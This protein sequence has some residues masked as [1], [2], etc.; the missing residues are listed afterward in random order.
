MPVPN[1]RRITDTIKEP[2]D[3]KDKS[4]YYT[5]TNLL[6]LQN[7]MSALNGSQFKLWMY[8]SKNQNGHKFELSSADISKW[9]L[10][11]S[12]YKRAFWDLVDY[13][14]LEEVEYNK[15]YKF[16]EKPIQKEEPIIEIVKDED[17][18]FDF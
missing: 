4:H 13:G 18:D 1:Q 5:A 9:G 15:Y 8:L 16:H 12:A 10:S 11:T 7:A 14:Y 3:K 17:E 2:C 6:A